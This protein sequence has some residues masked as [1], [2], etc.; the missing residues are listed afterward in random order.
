MMKGRWRWYHAVLLL[1]AR[2]TPQDTVPLSYSHRILQWVLD[3][4]L[5]QEHIPSAH[6][7]KHSLK[8]RDPLP[9]NHAGHKAVGRRVRQVGNSRL[10]DET[11]QQR[12]GRGEIITALRLCAVR[13]RA[14]SA[15]LFFPT[16]LCTQQR[17]DRK[18]RS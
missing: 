12:E 14:L 6:S 18:P 16:P 9:V 5:S 15:T 2:P 1:W 4:S 17:T 7:P 3:F 13:S 11:E 10:G 8:G